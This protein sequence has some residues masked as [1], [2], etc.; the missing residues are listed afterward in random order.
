M[1]K[2]WVFLYLMIAVMVGMVVVFVLML[3]IDFVC[4]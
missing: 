4:S 3:F 2:M 1:L